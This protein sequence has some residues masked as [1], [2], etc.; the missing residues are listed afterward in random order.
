MQ[1]FEYLVRSDIHEQAENIARTFGS[2]ERERLSAYTQYV[3]AELNKLGGQGWELVQAPD[4][5]TNRNWIFK[6]ALA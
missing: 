6:R 2:R 5:A 4:V 1:R 3:L